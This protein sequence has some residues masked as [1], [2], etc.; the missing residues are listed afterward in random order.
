LGS[1]L[2]PKLA[3]E[4][5]VNGPEDSHMREQ[6][7]NYYSQCYRPRYAGEEMG[8]CDPVSGNQDAEQDW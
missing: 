3:S 2:A 7:Q 4:E 6:R 8:D 1:W 5:S